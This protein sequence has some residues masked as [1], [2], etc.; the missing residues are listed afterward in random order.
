MIIKIKKYKELYSLLLKNGFRRSECTIENLRV[1]WQQDLQLNRYKLELASQQQSSIFEKWNTLT[2]DVSGLLEDENR[3]FRK[4]KSKIDLNIRSCSKRVLQV[5]Y[6]L[7]DIKES[8]VKSLI[9]LD[10]KVIK[11]EK[12]IQFLKVLYSKLKGVLE[13]SK[14]RK[15]N[16]RVLTDLYVGNYFDKV[17]SKGTKYGKSQGRKGKNYEF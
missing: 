1:L 14:Q 11:Q 16:I 8:A 13:A 12:K 10:S 9:E 3:K 4:L 7:S 5:K 6:G 2:E 15:S 17:T